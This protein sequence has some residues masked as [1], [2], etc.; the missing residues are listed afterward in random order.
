MAGNYN[1]EGE[2]LPWNGGT[3][4]GY[5]VPQG[6]GEQQYTQQRGSTKDD[7]YVEPR[8]QARSECLSKY[9]IRGA[10]N[11]QGWHNFDNVEIRGNVA[12][13]TAR[14]DGGR[15]F[16]LRVDSCSGHVIDADPVVVYTDRAPPPRFYYGPDYYYSPRP[17]VGL[18]FGGGYGGHHRHW[19]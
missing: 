2:R 16:E 11:S 9:G 1:D 10:L 8:R 12:Y 3:K 15:R 7:S 17:A 19:R 6:P 4:D 18:Y 14:N 13:M 5:P